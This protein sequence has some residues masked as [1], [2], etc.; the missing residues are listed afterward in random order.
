ML[1]EN[2][3]GDNIKRLMEQRELSQF[4]LSLAAEVPQSRISNILS[5]R[6]KNP[7]VV[8]VVR[9]AKAL[10]VTVDELLSNSDDHH[11]SA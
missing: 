5:G 4:R 1:S 9:L 7:R 8:T 2:G 3:L 11:L 10:G 6:V